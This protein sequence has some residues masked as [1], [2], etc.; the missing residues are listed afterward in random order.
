MNAQ[1]SS[2]SSDTITDILMGIAIVV[3]L[4]VG[5]A[6]AEFIYKSIMALWVDKVELFPDTYASGTRMFTAIQNPHNPAAKTVNVSDNQRSGVEFS[7]AMFVYLKS[8]CFAS[9]EQKLLHI[10]HKGYNKPYPLM[11]P[12]IFTWG[13]KN[14][15]RI[16]M[17]CYDSWNN[18]CEVENIPVD[19][20][21]HLVVS[22]KGNTI[23]IYV[24]GSL[25]Q[26]VNLSGN[27]PPYQ[28]YGDVYLFNPRKLA[29]SKSITT[30]LANDAE[31]KGTG[32]NSSLQFGG[33]ATGMVSRV[34]YFSYALSYTEIQKLMAMGPSSVMSGP[35]M[36]MTPYLSDTWWVNAQGP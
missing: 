7:Y 35:D 17:N 29:I 11:A 28:N 15:I 10:L 23:F 26:K 13:H 5:L 22:C 27:T 1:S 30:S 31:F 36:S 20:W 2:G 14:V 34:Y 4:Y 18:W 24:N 16:F 8:E 21:F 6:T 25:K 3:L 12:G 19:K 9:G 32:S 33:A